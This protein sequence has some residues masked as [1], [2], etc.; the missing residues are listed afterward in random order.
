VLLVLQKP[1]VVERRL[2]LLSKISHGPAV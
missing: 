2:Y 1:P